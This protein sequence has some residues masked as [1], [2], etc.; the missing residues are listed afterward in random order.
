MNN[1]YL[2][3]FLTSVLFCLL[4]LFAFSQSNKNISEYK[5]LEQLQTDTFYSSSEFDQ[6]INYLIVEIKRPVFLSKDTS[7]ILF[8]NNTI[9]RITDRDL[10]GYLEFSKGD[11]IEGYP[12]EYSVTYLILNKSKKFLSIVFNIY[13]SAGGSGN[14]YSS[15]FY[16]VTFDLIKKKTLGIGDIIDSVFYKQFDSLV[17]VKIKN[18]V[19][20]DAIKD[21]FT[22][23]Y[24]Y[25]EAKKQQ[26]IDNWTEAFK[27]KMKSLALSDKNILLYINFG[28]S[29]YSYDEEIKIPINECLPYLSKDFVEFIK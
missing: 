8:V 9:K 10:I 22:D 23:N 14:G 16:P 28:E 4:Y 18:L 27:T 3:L 12:E 25:I 2:R 11:S 20:E 24:E 13:E 21:G 19:Y 1:N 26:L 17:S 7:Q 29:H 6:E 15:S 5:I